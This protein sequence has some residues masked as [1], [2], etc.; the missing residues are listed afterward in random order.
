LRRPFMPWDSPYKA[1]SKF[2]SGVDPI[3]S[4]ADQET[5]SRYSPWRGNECRGDA[6]S[7]P[8]PSRSAG[9]QPLTHRRDR[10]RR[11]C[12]HRPRPRARIV[13]KARWEAL[14]VGTGGVV[15][16]RW[17]EFAL[18]RAVPPGARL[19]GG[20]NQIRTIGRAEKETAVESGPAADHRRLARRSVLDDFIQLIGPASLVGNSR[21]TFHKSG[22]GGSNPIPSS[23]ESTSRAIHK[24]HLL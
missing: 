18:R 22:T 15:A 3:K 2:R 14:F 23:R 6:K 20:G 21:E 16:W 5:S 24:L 17:A 13:G 7:T 9:L 8:L 11:W 10:F 1:P 19:A 4:P 12:T